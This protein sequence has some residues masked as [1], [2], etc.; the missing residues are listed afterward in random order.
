MSRDP[1]APAGELPAVEAQPTHGVPDWMRALDE[2]AVALVRQQL[3]SEYR[4]AVRRYLR[5][6]DDSLR[7]AAYGSTLDT[8]RQA[9]LYAVRLDITVQRERVR[10]F[11]AQ[12]RRARGLQ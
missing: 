9:E 1:S 7:V 8:A 5:L 3:M 4:R 12:L 6:V 2:P 11:E 10:R